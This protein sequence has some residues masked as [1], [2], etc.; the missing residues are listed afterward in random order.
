MLRFVLELRG[1]GAD[2]VLEPLYEYH[3]KFVNPKIRRLREHHFRDVLA[4][5]EPWLRLALIQAA[6]SINRDKI[7]DTWIE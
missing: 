6:Y 1:S 5:D 4:V 7:R 2:S 3:E